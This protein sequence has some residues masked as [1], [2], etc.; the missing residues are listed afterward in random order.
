MINTTMKAAI[1]TKYGTPEVLRIDRV[2]KPVPEDNEILVKIMASAVNSGDVRVRGLAVEGFLKI[3]MRFV[4]GFSGPRK[5][6]L[7]TVFSGIIEETGKNAKNF[8]IGDEVFG[9][10]GFRFGT[11]AEYITLPGKSIVTK[12]PFN[13]TFEEAAA[14]LFGGH[15]AIYF[16]EKLKIA[17]R[18][19]PK[20]LI[21]GATGAVGTAA[22]Q[23]AR[24][25]HAEVTAVCGENGQNLAKTLGADHIILYN[26]EDFTKTP[27][28]FDIIFDAVGKTS[29][30]QCAHLLNP[31]GE[32]KS[33]EGLDVAVD[34]IEQLEL[35]R[36]LFENGK[37]Q[38][39]IDRIYSID[40]IV[41][42]HR[43][44]DTG[45]K[46]GNVVLKING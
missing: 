17:T 29:K 28:R 1:C 36:T 9:I 38:A 11:H 19:S 33:V 37:Y 7:G 13:A 3:V 25:Y 41:E 12:K 4:L 21:Y 6:I 14:I 30:K 20:V 10:T 2:E 18:T 39:T 15:S 43:Y 45:R 34:K 46:K 22:L 23:I 40:E 24:H 31:G 8:K 42:A 26:K 27:D 5:P 35:L 32:Y 16:L 44:V